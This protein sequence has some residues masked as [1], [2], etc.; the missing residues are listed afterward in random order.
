MPGGSHVFRCMMVKAYI[1]FEKILSTQKTSS[2]LPLQEEK[3][4]R[5]K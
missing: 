1:E 2:S 5:E 3:N 4:K